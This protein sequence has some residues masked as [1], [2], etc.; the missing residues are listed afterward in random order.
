MQFSLY[1]KAFVIGLCA[2]VTTAAFTPGVVLAEQ[3]GIVEE[4]VVT[5]S[6]IRGTPEDA[7]LPVDVLSQQDMEEIGSPSIVELVRNLGVT[8]ANLGETNQFTSGGQ[9]NEGIATVNLRGLG[10][11]RTLVLINGRRHVATELSGTDINAIPISSIGRMEI[12]KDGA[13]AVYG[14][15][16]IGG[17]VN[18]ITREGFEGFELGGNFQDVDESDGDWNVNAL[19]GTAGDNWNFMVA[20]EYGERAE[21]RIR[22]KDWALVPQSENPVGGWSGLGSPGNIVWYDNLTGQTLDVNITEPGGTPQTVSLPL[23]G[24]TVGVLP[25]EQCQNLGGFREVNQSCGFQYTFFDNLIEKTEQI[26]VYTEFNYDFNENHTLHIEALYSEVDLPEWKTSPSYPPQSF[27]TPDRFL[28]SDHPGLVDYQN[29]YGINTVNATSITGVLN[30][31]ALANNPNLADGFTVAPVD[32]A[33]LAGLNS[34]A[35]AYTVSRAF[36]VI[37]RFGTGEPES[38]Q[39]LTETYRLAAALEGQ[40]FDGEIDYKVS[41]SWSERDRFIG[42]QDMYVE[43]MALALQGYGGPNCALPGTTRDGGGNLIVDP[44]A[45]APGTGGCEYYNPFSRGIPGS[46]ING[47][48]NPDYNPAVANTPELMRWLIG[49]RGWD[50]SNSL[51]VVDAVISGETPIEVGGGVVGF[52][53]GA[54]MRRE[55]YVSDFGDLSDRAVNPCPWTLDLSVALGFTSEDQLTPNCSSPTGVAAFLAAS[56]EERTSRSVYAVFG[57]LAIPLADDI[58]VQ[59]AIRYEDYGG[60]IG[61]TIDPKLAASWRVTE[62]F[63]VRASVSTTFRAPPQSIL[64]GT[65]TALSYVSPTGAFKAIDTIGNPNLDSEKALSTNFGLIYQNEN[66]YGSI[67]FW[68]FDFEDSF[69]T[70]G[71]GS[72]VTAY[73]TT[74]ACAAG[75]VIVDNPTCNALRG[76]IFPV[77]AHTDDA[78]IERIAVNW[79]N[80]QDITTSGL[81]FRLEYDFHEVLDGS[82]TVGAEG[83]Y[84]LEYERDDQLDI[85]GILLGPGGDLS[86]QLNYNQGPAFTSKPELKMNAFAKYS[87]DGHTGQVIVRYISDYDDTGN[88]TNPLYSHLDTIDDHTTVDLHYNYTGLEGWNFSLN[89][90]NVADEDPPAAR[91]DLNYDPFTHNPFGRMIKVG[92]KYT[93]ER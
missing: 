77:A 25:D 35:T 16:A 54:Q 22:D 7:E 23:T 21:L 50:R 40:L 56:D 10:A 80:G 8:S 14:S 58:D 30:A 39:R 91:G 53:A 92:V 5:G 28:P 46:V 70:E 24:S 27:S 75:G 41:A 36:G 43:R 29:F 20:A 86:G 13:A 19:F 12:L 34:Q 84:L 52:A 37:G 9:S 15:D 59:A 2:V 61:S 74:N 26:K 45:A 83:T 69:Q 68:R 67:D 72:I 90:I 44:G 17:V 65:G 32:P 1:S 57:E 82:V 76:H 89:V 48:T 42:G 60:N 81:D 64:G 88:S 51:F 33:D 4:V 66:F 87:R 6:Y 71:F 78:D 85:G 38:K 63:S 62:A 49:D 18:I 93:L 55:R 3:D 73:Y 11:A 31:S 79:I 47:N